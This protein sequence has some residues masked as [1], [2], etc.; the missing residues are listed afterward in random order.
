MKEEFENVS[1]ENFSEI[2][3]NQTFDSRPKSTRYQYSYIELEDVISNPDEYIIPECQPACRAAWNKNIETFMVSNY[4]DE[5]LYVLFANLSF[6]N[7]EI[8]KKLIKLDMV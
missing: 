6:E 1:D 5:N 4:D 8:F 3:E 7:Q 2:E